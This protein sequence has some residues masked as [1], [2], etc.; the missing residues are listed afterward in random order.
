MHNVLDEA[1]EE[2]SFSSERPERERLDAPAA[3]FVRVLSAR[4][5][6]FKGSAAIPEPVLPRCRN[7]RNPLVAHGRIQVHATDALEKSLLK[8]PLLDPRKCRIIVLNGDHH[9]GLAYSP[10]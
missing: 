9:R 6:H 1:F 5:P 8:K 4:E 3:P 10:I 7:H 2:S